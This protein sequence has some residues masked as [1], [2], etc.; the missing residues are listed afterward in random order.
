MVYA[1][2]ARRALDKLFHLFQGAIMTVSRVLLALMLGA[3]V[4]VAA[5]EKAAPKAAAAKPAP[6]MVMADEV[7][8]GPAPPSLPAGAQLAVLFG[9]PGKKAP[10]AVRFKFPAGYVIPPHWHSGDEQLTVLSGT[11]LLSMGDKMDEASAHKLGAGSFHFLPGKM[12]H[13]A[14]AKDEVVL[15]LQGTGPFDIHYLNPADDPQK[16]AE[17]AK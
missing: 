1:A 11:F 9:D 12:H 3:V 2:A 6:V 8:F 14:M 17:A 4:S 13:A 5:A 16:K 10:F 15:Q 7:K